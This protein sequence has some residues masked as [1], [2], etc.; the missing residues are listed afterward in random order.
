MKSKSGYSQQG[1]LYLS[2]PLEALEIESMRRRERNLKAVE[3]L[4][5]KRERSKLLGNMLR[6]F[7]Q[8]REAMKIQKLSR[9]EVG[10][11]K[12]G[13][14][15]ISKLN[16]TNENDSG[17]EKKNL[18]R[19]N[20]LPERSERARNQAKVSAKSPS[21]DISKRK[22]PSRSRGR[23]PDKSQKQHSTPNF[24]NQPQRSPQKQKPR[25]KNE[26]QR[27]TELVYLHPKKNSYLNTSKKFKYEGRLCRNNINNA[28]RFILNREV[29]MFES[30]FVEFKRLKGLHLQMIVN[31]VGGFLNSY[32]G[33]LY[34]GIS[35]DG[36]VKGIS[37]S[38]DD[39]DQF[40]VDLDRTLRQF[41]PTVFPDQIRMQFHEICANKKMKVGFVLILFF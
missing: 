29:D 20:Y 6:N 5:K 8:N 7:R 16:R 2:A 27:T 41:I 31:Y 32:G 23:N 15:K 37:L 4:N 13:G 14:F 33:S 26:R 3:L 35:D 24:R 38:R 17:Q 39:I 22:T 11:N 9:S 10:K 1:S 30:Q 18:G 25:A 19:V 40:Q 34:I 21:F 12:I 28:R 36:R